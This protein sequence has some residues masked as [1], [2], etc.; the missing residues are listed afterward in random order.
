MVYGQG[1]NGMNYII[2]RDF[3]MKLV[4]KNNYKNKIMEYGGTSHNRSVYAAPAVAGL[5]FIR[6][7]HLLCSFPRL[8]PARLGGRSLLRKAL[9]C[10]PK[11]RKQPE[12]YAKFGLKFL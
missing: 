3:V 12:R 9:L 4:R 8:I 7:G 1:L 2:I 6:P 11:R 10:P 5:A